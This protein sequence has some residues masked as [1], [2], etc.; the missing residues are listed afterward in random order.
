MTPTGDKFMDHV[1]VKPKPEPGGGGWG[2]AIAKA[3]P[4]RTPKPIG[5]FRT[6]T[7]ERARRA[8]L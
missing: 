6:K 3:E 7:G 8:L 2:G 1:S 5:N 4:F